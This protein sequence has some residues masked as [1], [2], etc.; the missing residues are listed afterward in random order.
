[1][2]KMDAAS[3]SIIDGVLNLPN[4]KGQRLL[5]PL[6]YGDFQRNPLT[7]K[8][9]KR[10]SVTMT[11]SKVIVAFSKESEAVEPTGKVG[12]D[13]NQKSLVGSDG[14]KYDLSDVARRHTEYGVRRS[15]FYAKY[16]GD[17]RLK[18]KFASTRRERERA[19]QFLHRV[20][21]EVIERVTE[22]KQ[23]IILERLK[24]I[25]YA[26]RKGMARDGEVGVESPCGPSGNFKAISNTRLCG[27]ACLS[28][29]SMRQGHLRFAPTAHS[30]TRS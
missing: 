28:S 15:E 29:M 23:A 10:G 20:A 16:S 2:L 18:K 6:G 26:H 24:G 12:Y 14:S 13:L 22:R 17:R 9:L 30:S 11:E 1:M 21:K 7:D 8:T 25:R 4:R 5:I 3:Y 27:L 19:K